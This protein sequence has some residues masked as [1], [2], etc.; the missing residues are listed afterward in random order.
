MPGKLEVHMQNEIESSF[1]FT[2]ICVYTHTQIYLYA[3]I[4]NM[5]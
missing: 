4:S 1:Y 2:H 3:H 5:K